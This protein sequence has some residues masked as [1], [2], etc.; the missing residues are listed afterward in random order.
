MADQVRIELKEGKFAVVLE[1]Y[2]Q[3]QE[4]DVRDTFKDAEDYAFYL[5]RL[6]KLEVYYQ[7]QKI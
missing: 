6:V 7:G 3:Q 1:Q 2:G 4:I 5:S